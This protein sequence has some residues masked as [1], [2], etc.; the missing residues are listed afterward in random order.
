MKKI[1][2][3]LLLILA[4]VY[5][6]AQ[7]PQGFTYQA[8]VSDEQGQ[9]IENQKVSVRI[10]LL[11]S[12]MEPNYVEIH[13]PTTSAGGLFT[14]VVGEGSSVD[15]KSMSE[16]VDWSKGAWYIKSEIAPTGGG[17]YLIISTQR[18]MSVPY[19]LYAGNVQKDDTSTKSGGETHDYIDSLYNVLTERISQLENH[20]YSNSTNLYNYKTAIV[21][22]FIYGP[23]GALHNVTWSNTIGVSDFIEVKG[24]D[25]ISN[26]RTGSGVGT[27]N[28]YDSNKNL[29]RSIVNNVQYEYEEGDCYVRIAFEDYL[30][31]HANYGQELLPFE[32]YSEDISTRLLN[33]KVNYLFDVV[34]GIVGKG[35]SNN[36]YDKDKVTRYKFIYGR[37]GG[38]NDAS[39]NE[40]IG[41]SDYIPVFRRNIISNARTGQGVGSFNV[42]DADK[43]LLRTIVNDPQYLYQKGEFYVRIAF[44]NW[45]VGQANYG[46]VLLPYEEYGDTTNPG[47]STN[48][49]YEERLAQLEEL[50]TM[51][52]DRNSS[53]NIYNKATA[54]R[55]KFI[56]GVN[57]NINNASWNQT[58]G[59]SDYIPVYRRNIISNARTGQGVGSYNVY[60]ADKN[61]LRTIVNDAHY[62]YQDGE[63]YVRIAFDNYS[64]GQA[65][66][67][68]VLQ[69]Y[70]D[71]SE[72]Y[73]VQ[74]SLHQMYGTPAISWV[75]DDFLYTNPANTAVYDAVH[76]WCLAN[77][78]RGDIAFIPSAEGNAQMALKVDTLKHWEQQG[79]NVLMHPIHSGW[80][81]DPFGHFTVN[82]N[83][84]HNQLTECIA[85]FSRFGFSSTNIVIYPG[86]SGQD[87]QVREIVRN[88]VD[89]GICWNNDRPS[90]HLTE[91][92]RYQLK[93]LNIQMTAN[94][95]KTQIKEAIREAVEN[96]DWIILGCHVYQFEVSDVLDETSK[97]TAN[98]FEILEYANSLCRIRPVSAVWNERRI[99]F[100]I[101][102]K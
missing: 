98:L 25:I 10:S 57:G 101:D 45:A 42:Y 53:S 61:L 78:V 37:N 8:V 51:L 12:E 96:G 18:L 2:L 32:D 64:S 80:Y 4:A 3:S 77:N 55:Q 50:V 11:D 94:N 63:Y 1:L 29:L 69:P 88:F 87:P 89:L 97:T 19:A 100:D 7:V 67:G 16:S 36:L 23:T 22:K 24:N 85:D 62:I 28:V 34:A 92:G 68:D 14:I 93:R 21:G 41:V 20:T 75:D 47:S 65:N 99:M 76:A 66:Y 60:D 33:E 40:T 83:N 6:S 58:I 38:I 102:G 30:T 17:D 13:T 31:G 72:S 35:K 49:D 9:P 27:Y 5:V 15:N 86:S 54:T 84:V 91:N 95:T 43:N 48:S 90:N 26:G 81:N 71:Y 56:Y 74:N 52:I 79:F 82:Y 44:D 59:V 70:E 73:A 46:T 39:W